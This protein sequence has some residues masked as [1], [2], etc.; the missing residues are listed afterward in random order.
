MKKIG[1]YII[2]TLLM[3][4][5]AF[6]AAGMLFT[7]KAGASFTANDLI[8][9]P[10]YDNTGAMSA[11]A[12]DNWLNNNFPNG[13][14]TPNHGFRALDPIGYSPSGGFTFGGLYVSA[15]QVIYDSANVYGINPQV[16]LATL[17]K[18][19]S[20]VTGGGG[21]S[22]LAYTAAAGYGCP[23]GGVTY[24]YSGINL[25]SLN[26]NEVSSVN[27]TCVNS[28]AKAG[29]SQQVIRAAWLLRFGEQRSQ[30][31][32]GWAVIK[33]N[34]DNS[35]DPGTCYGGPM[36]Q[37]LLKRCSSDPSPV[38]YD[39]YATI[40]GSSV[41]M[42]NGATAALYW[43]TPHFAGNQNF[44]NIFT[45]WFGS[46]FVASYAWTP[47]SQYS[48]TDSSKTTPVDL[49][50]LSPGQRVY[51]GFKALNTGNQ[52]WT[53][54]GANPIRVGTSGPNDRSS[55]FCDTGTWLG[56]NR[57]SNMIESSV[58][59]GQTGTFEFWYQ[60]PNTL[61]GGTYWE[62][63][64][65]MVEGVNWMNDPQMSFYTVISPKIYSWSP[66]SQYSYTDSSKTTPVDLS[67]L[68]TGQ[69]VYIGFTAQ[70]TGNQTWT[71]TGANPIRVGTAGPNDRSSI[72]C[73][74]G[75]WLGCNRPAA[76]K[77]SSVA[78]GQ[79]G[80]FEFW[81]QAPNTSNGSI[82]WEQ[83][84]LMAEGLTWM[85][86]PQMSFYTIVKPAVYSW[87]PV[88]QYS[89]TDSSKTTPVDL[90]QLSSGQRVYIG[91]T[92]Q[93]TGNQT[94][95]NTGSHTV[96]VGTAGPNDRSSAFC[97]SSTWLGCNRPT[98]LIQSSVAPGQT[99]TFEFWYQA[100]SNSSGNTYWER[101]NLM[102]EGIDWMND[103][104]MSF[105][106]ILH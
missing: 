104:Q 40:D 59:P 75:T 13:C 24:N 1:L 85:N 7:Q 18:E 60:A 4:S 10:V 5:V 57:P 21:C 28:A 45:G 96:R 94:W 83:F 100:P 98:T 3:V 17:Q 101:F 9:D 70:N 19:Q 48:Y 49:S 63:F 35:D 47:T 51:I 105:R 52:T 74:T 81:Y 78:P 15:G 55:I 99:G 97:D 93:N 36:T 76:M 25:Y 65:L 92:A 61:N 86:D 16:L 95:T 84:N 88:S 102:L 31:N 29:F 103:P 44:D 58:A 64:N 69:R 6:G 80:T 67:K 33:G 82:H 2:S 66:V 68:N 62:Q 72:F 39:G 41:H 43:Y 50:H 22:T 34:W 42:D 11:F 30:G 90:T 12:I 46:A 56:C 26:G 32:V 23:D 71:N 53:N 79:T 91:F 20:L 73:D 77:E 106:T 8:D 27:G 14:I 38:N 87:S 89:Y 37:G 54:T